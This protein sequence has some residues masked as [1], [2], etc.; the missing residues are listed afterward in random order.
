MNMQP[1]RP[2][3]AAWVALFAL[4]LIWGG[5]F[6]GVALAL[7]G[8]CHL[9]S[10]GG[11]GVMLGP[12][13]VVAI[14]VPHATL[15]QPVPQRFVANIFLARQSDFQPATQRVFRSGQHSSY[16]AVPVVETK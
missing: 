2:S 15:A 12:L 7:T 16:I 1:P 5:S 8:L 6:L 10:G 4:G 14:V 13:A 3:P 9:V 11:L